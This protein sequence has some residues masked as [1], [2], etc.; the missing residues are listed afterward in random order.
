MLG[1]DGAEESETAMM[2]FN[3]A[4]EIVSELAV[5]FVDARLK[6]RVAFHFLTFSPSTFDR[7][8]IL[9]TFYVSLFRACY[10]RW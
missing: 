9:G 1:F 7:G 8:T 3:F 4:L 6:F 2:T 10:F 5:D